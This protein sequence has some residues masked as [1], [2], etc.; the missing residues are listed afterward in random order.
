M[1]ITSARSLTIQFTGDRTQ[2]QTVPA[3]Q[4][5]GSPG[6]E[7]IKALAIG[8]N[9]I[10]VPAATGFVATAVTIIPPVANPNAL[11]LKGIAGDTGIPLHKTDPTTIAIDSTVVNFSIN[12]AAVTTVRLI[13]T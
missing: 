13:W 2:T 7:E 11:T 9:V 5:A 3:A 10:T 12:A 8:N 6:V 1:S 4:N